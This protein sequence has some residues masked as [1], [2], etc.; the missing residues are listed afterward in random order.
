LS[1]ARRARLFVDAACTDWQLEVIRDDAMVVVSEL[2]ANAVVHA[3]TG[4]RVVRHRVYEAVSAVVSDPSLRS[5]SLISVSFDWCSPL[6]GM[7]VGW[8]WV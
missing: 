3:G 6:T 5:D 8:I 1:S 4:C 2:V 7:Q